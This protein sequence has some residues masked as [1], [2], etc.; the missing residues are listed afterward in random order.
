MIVIVTL[1][2]CIVGLVAGIVAMVAYDAWEHS[3][4]IRAQEEI[5]AAVDQEWAERDADGAAFCRWAAQQ[6]KGGAR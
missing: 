3:Q 1:V 5:A 4:D 2:A 6:Y